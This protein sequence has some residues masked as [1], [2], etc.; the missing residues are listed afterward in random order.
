[1]FWGF[2]YQ[3]QSTIDGVLEKP[4]CTLEMLLEEEDI[5]QECKGHHTK[6]I[7]FLAQPEN[8]SKMIELLTFGDDNYDETKQF[9]YALICSEIIC[10]ELWPILDGLA[11]HPEIL[12]R[13]WSFI[14]TDEQLVPYR[15]NCFSR[16]CIVLIQTKPQV[17]INFI[18]TKENSI[19]NILKHIENSSISDLLLKLMLIEDID[20][21]YQI[22]EWLSDEHVIAQLI[23]RL[24]PYNEPEQHSLIIQI[25][26]EINALN[27]NQVVMATMTESL[28]ASGEEG[29]LLSLTQPKSLNKISLIDEIKEEE[30]FTKL[31]DFM[32]DNE[33][34]YSTS[35]LINGINIIIELIRKYCSD[36]EQIEYQYHQYKLSQEN[37]ASN[38]NSNNGKNGNPLTPQLDEISKPS[39]EQLY[40]LATSINSILHI[41]NT[42]LADFKFLLSHPK[43]ISGPVDTTLGKQI[44]LGSERL[45]IC[46]L[47]AEIMHLQYLFTSSPLF[48][49]VINSKEPPENQDSN[50][51][52]NNR[53][54]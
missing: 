15:A 3:S 8:L 35:S 41:I 44:P 50:N 28:V 43:S 4:E 29:S 30:I 27:Y 49:E 5:I 32:F 52:D 9:K 2:G 38:G 26:L 11:N 31:I 10:C 21:T 33:A 37:N 19:S 22:I 39:E 17:M 6:L 42:H 20:N 16:I 13:F 46:E 47:F 23:D 1:M 51:N 54:V 48:G 14:E 45:R 7:E 36:I 53:T 12:D 25:L 40:M 24:N 18:K 34:P